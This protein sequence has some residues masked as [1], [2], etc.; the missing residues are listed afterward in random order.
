MKKGRRFKVST[1]RL[2]TSA[3]LSLLWS[4]EPV[5]LG[6]DGA[7]ALASWAQTLGMPAW[8]LDDRARLLELL[9]R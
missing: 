4:G 3:A 1:Y 2:Q 6:G 8:L 7:H 5:M 9:R